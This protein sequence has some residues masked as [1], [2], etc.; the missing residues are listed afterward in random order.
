VSIVTGLSLRL[1]LP[2]GAPKI[3][4][5]ISEMQLQFVQ[6]VVRCIPYEAGAFLP[7]NKTSVGTCPAYGGRFCLTRVS[8]QLAYFVLRRTLAVGTRSPCPL[9][10]AVEAVRSKQYLDRVSEQ[11]YDAA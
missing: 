4:M 2:S 7:R 1:W 3:F 10:C 8:G 11:R 5:K 6:V 9:M